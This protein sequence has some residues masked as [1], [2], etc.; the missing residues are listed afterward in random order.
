MAIPSDARRQCNDAALMCYGTAYIFENRAKSIRRKIHFLS[1][2]G[3]A[4]PASV[5]AIVGSFTLKP[6]IF[7]IILFFAAILGL[8]QLIFSIWSLVAEWNNRLSYY[9]ES[10]SSNYRLADLYEKLAN[11]TTL[12]DQDFST[13]LGVLDVESQLRADLDNRHDVTDKE[14]RIGMRAGLRKYQRGCV[15]CGKIPTDMKPN[16]CGV[17][18]K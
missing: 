3:I 18:G 4:V 17:C 15:G 10:K 12:S 16:E 7:S 14:K 6:E 2:L 11:I 1:F 5:G 9:L 13:K 8:I